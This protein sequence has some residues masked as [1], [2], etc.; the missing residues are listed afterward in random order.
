MYLNSS[1]IALPRS[2]YQKKKKKKKCLMLSNAVKCIIRDQEQCTLLVFHCW[3]Y[4]CGSLSSTSSVAPLHPEQ[5]PWSQKGTTQPPH[6]CI[7]K[8]TLAWHS[9]WMW[10][11]PARFPPSRAT[12]R[13]GRQGQGGRSSTDSVISAVISA[14]L[15]EFDRSAPLC[16]S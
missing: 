2:G 8:S 14:A 16:Y 11:L 12:S 4:L 10:G 5:P 1:E 13:A 6:P 3:L 9:L 15:C 7:Q